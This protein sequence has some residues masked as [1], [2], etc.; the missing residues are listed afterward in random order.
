MAPGN[1]RTESVSG[2]DNASNDSEYKRDS[3]GNENIHN[4]ENPNSRDG[5]GNNS[6]KSSAIPGCFKTA[7]TKLMM[8]KI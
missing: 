7:D 6:T 1:R 4:R 8:Q 3:I 5:T 2:R